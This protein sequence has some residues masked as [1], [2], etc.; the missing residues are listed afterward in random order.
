M[1]LLKMKELRAMRLED[2]KEKLESLEDELMHERGVAAMGGAPPSPGRLRALRKNV[3]RIRT[4]MRE[5]EIKKETGGKKGQEE[6]A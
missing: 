6:N 5:L 1:A 4:I 2:L 3:A